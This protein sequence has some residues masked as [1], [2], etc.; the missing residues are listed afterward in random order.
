MVNVVALIFTGLTLVSVG[1]YIGGQASQDYFHQ[2]TQYSYSSTQPNVVT[3]I[4]LWS[5]CSQVTYPGPAINPGTSSQCYNV[6]NSNCGTSGFG[7]QNFAVFSGT[8]CDKYQAARAL[9]AVATI[10]GG[11]AAVLMLVTVF[12]HHYTAKTIGGLLGLVSAFFGIV[13]FAIGTALANTNS[14]LNDP[15]YGAGYACS[16]S[17]WCI[18]FTT[19]VF[20]LLYGLPPNPAAQEKQPQAQLTTSGKL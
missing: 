17:A 8:D 19:S 1:L 14:N 20:Y 16:V 12:Y 3:Q 15:T 6:Y 11:F 2:T 10:F 5:Y 18:I 4:G 9:L 13:S 7:I